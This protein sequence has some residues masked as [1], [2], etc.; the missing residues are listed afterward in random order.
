MGQNVLVIINGIVVQSL[1][2]MLLNVV[3][4]MFF[5]FLKMGSINVMVGNDLIVIIIVV[6]NFV[7]GYNVLCM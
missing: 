6:I 1:I 4:G 3:D 5:M 2:N 7:N